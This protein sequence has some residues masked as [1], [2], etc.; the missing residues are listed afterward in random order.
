MCP[1][2]RTSEIRRRVTSQTTALAG[3]KGWAVADQHTLLNPEVIDGVLARAE[4]AL[5]ANTSI[6][7][8]SSLERE[9]AKL[10]RLSAAVAA[11]G[12]LTSLVEAVQAVDERLADWRGLLR[13]HPGS[14]AAHVHGH[15]NHRTPTG[16]AGGTKVG[17]PNGIRTHVSG[18]RAAV[19]WTDRDGTSW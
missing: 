11:G 8:R 19:P 9:L 4:A 5:A 12:E 1:G 13:R 14:R 3:K 18:L 2:R 16:G 6:E 17:V 15:R 7:R 10:K